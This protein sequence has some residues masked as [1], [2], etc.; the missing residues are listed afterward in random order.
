MVAHT[1]SSE[2]ASAGRPF[3]ISR[4]FDAPRE[5]VYRAWTE[6]D[7]LMRWFGPRGLTYVTGSID[8]RPGGVAMYCLR[9]P[10]GKEL[11][12][13]WVFCEVLAPERLSFVNSFSNQQGGLERHPMS[14]TWPLEMLTTVTFAATAPAKTTLQLVWTPFN[15]N[16][17]ERR[18]FDA[19]FGSM[20]QGWGGTLDQLAAFLAQG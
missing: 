13:K 15:A 16:A 4:V 2:T 19:G 11:W 1:S 17:E 14:P 5:L 6:Q 7:R 12:G 20:E 9:M 8:L 10:D 18:T 3:I